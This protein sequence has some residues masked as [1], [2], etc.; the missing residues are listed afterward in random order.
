MDTEVDQRI[1]MPSIV[2]WRGKAQRFVRAVVGRRRWPRLDA[3]VA[4]SDRAREKGFAVPDALFKSALDRT[5][6]QS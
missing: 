2:C 4:D 3:Y 1:L 6:T 5:A